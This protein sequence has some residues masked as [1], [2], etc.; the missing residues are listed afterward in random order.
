MCGRFTF[1]SNWFRNPMPPF[2]VSDMGLVLKPISFLTNLILFQHDIS[3]ITQ[4]SPFVHR[5]LGVMTPFNTGI[6]TGCQADFSNLPTKEELLEYKEEQ[7][8]RRNSH[9][10]TSSEPPPQSVCQNIFKLFCSCSSHAS[11]SILPIIIESFS[12]TWENLDTW[13]NRPAEKV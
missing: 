5:K 4:C 3:L 6:H 9:S 2:G 7:M 12:A 13:P 11:K 10:K 1:L 8:P